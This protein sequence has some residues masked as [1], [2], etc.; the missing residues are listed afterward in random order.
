MEGD[1]REIYSEG[2]EKKNN[3]TTPKCRISFSPL[4]FIIF[5]IINIFIESQW[6]GV[7]SGERRR[8]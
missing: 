2:N 4:S 1:K 3:W 5:Y 8:V 6:E 7:C